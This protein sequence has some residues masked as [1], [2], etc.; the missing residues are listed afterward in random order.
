MK[1]VIIVERNERGGIFKQMISTRNPL[2]RGNGLF[3][4]EEVDML[5]GECTEKWDSLPDEWTLE[6][7]DRVDI[8][9]YIDNPNL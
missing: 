7:T 9:W 3:S 5:T 2:F 6:T 8:D 4:Y 1:V